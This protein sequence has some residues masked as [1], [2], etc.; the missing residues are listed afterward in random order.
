M[1]KLLIV[2]NSVVAKVVHV[3]TVTKVVVVVISLIP[4][5]VLSVVRLELKCRIIQG[6]LSTNLSLSQGLS[7]SLCFRISHG[8][9]SS[10]W[11][12]LSLGRSLPIVESVPS[13]LEQSVGFLL[14]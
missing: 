11:V 3:G 12:S 5:V 8:D 14:S 13:L 4:V 7:L 6:K 1:G 2:H 10:L 9:C